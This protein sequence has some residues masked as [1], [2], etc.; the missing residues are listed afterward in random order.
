[1]ECEV[2]YKTD[3]MKNKMN[4]VHQLLHC[5]RIARQNISTN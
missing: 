5:M 1:M 3:A 2:L 4:E